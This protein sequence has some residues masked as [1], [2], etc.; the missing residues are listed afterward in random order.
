MDFSFAPLF[1][2]LL[3]SISVFLLFR[4]LSQSHDVFLLLF[5]SLPTELNSEHV[6]I[7]LFHVNLYH[8]FLSTLTPQNSH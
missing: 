4:F 8:N 2:L 1:V 3:P 7:C 6:L 5:P